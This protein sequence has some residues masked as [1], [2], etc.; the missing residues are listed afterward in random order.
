MIEINNLTTE[1]IDENLARKLADIVLRGEGK[2]N[3][4]FSLAFVGQGRMRQVN[5]KFRN[6][7]RVTDVL[8]FPESKVSLEKFKVGGSVKTQNLGEIIICV[9]EVKKNAKRFDF[10]FQKELSQVLIHGI[11]H[12]LG[13]DHET[14]EK[15][16]EKMREKE[17]Q[18]L[19]LLPPA[20]SLRGA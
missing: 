18:Y 6:K 13:F 7:N 15:D 17:E 12:L 16:A 2:E 9:R 11:L 19:K 1:D 5:K 14:N 20:S 4:D 10:S 3:S 8:S